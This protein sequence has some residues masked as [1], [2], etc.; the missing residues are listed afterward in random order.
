M[1]LVCNPTDHTT[2]SSTTAPSH[3]T[4]LVLACLQA[5]VLA[6]EA[7][8]LL[9]ACTLW[10]GPHEPQLLLPTTAAAT[11][12]RHHTNRHTARTRSSKASAAH[13]ASSHWQAAW[14]LSRVISCSGYTV[15]CGMTADVA[16]AGRG[17]TGMLNRPP[18]KDVAGV[19]RGAAP[20]ASSLRG[21]HG[22]R[23]CA[24]RM[25]AARSCGRAAAWLLLLAAEVVAAA[26]AATQQV[27]QQGGVAGHWELLC[28]GAAG[29]AVQV[30]G[31]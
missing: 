19:R 21:G 27:Y 7:P 18:M 30:L 31:P 26:A 5:R 1:P 24:E 17:T 11:A 20:E 13:A 28:G 9:T 4:T 2:D 25:E 8:C 29:Q 6:A 15:P 23:S 16:A 14:T 3:A 22:R 12:A 10:Q